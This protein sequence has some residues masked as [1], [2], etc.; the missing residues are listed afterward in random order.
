MAPNFFKS[1]GGFQDFSGIAE[2]SNFIR[3]PEDWVVILTDV[4][5]STAA[6]ENGRYK[7]VNTVGA[8]SIVAVQNALNEMELPFSFGG[9]GA[10]LLIPR[11]CEGKV[12]PVLN[13]LRD[14]ASNAFQL[15]LRI[16]RVG[17]EEIY[18]AGYTIEVAKY[19]ITTGKCIAVFRGGGLSYADRLMKSDQSGRFAIPEEEKGDCDLKGLSCRWN[20]I[21]S[22]RG[23]VLSL[24]IQP[25]KPDSSHIFLGLIR[26]FD[27]ILSYSLVDSN[28]VNPDLMSYDSFREIVKR[29]IRFHSKFS[30]AWV[31]RYLEILAAVVIFRYRVPPVLF[32]PTRYA[33]A[34]RT[35]SD[36]I[37]LADSLQMV[38]DCTVEQKDRIISVLESAKERGDLQYGLFESNH[39]IMTCYVDDLQDGNHLHFIDGGEGGYAM[40]SKSLKQA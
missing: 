9:D 18:S 27:E 22:K 12:Y 24:I 17:V 4:I 23:R 7:D 8:A 1:L 20:E 39:S 16:G 11:D 34:M 15:D 10:T 38:I 19:E 13:S 37:K 29:E 32:S 26:E 33:R 6:I 36:Y 28:P 25:E 3:V 31:L 2:D 35:H 40:A 14:I 5:S 30:L 21:P